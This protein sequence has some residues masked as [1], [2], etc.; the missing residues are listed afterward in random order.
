MKSLALKPGQ[1]VADIG[2]GTGFIAN[3][4]FKLSGRNNPIWRVDPSLEMQEVA[5]QKEGLYPVQKTAEE[6]CSDP[7]ISEIFD[8]VVCVTSAHHFVDPDAVYKGI[9][10]SLRPSGIFVQ[11]NTLKSGHPVFK[12]AEKLVSKS[13][14]RERETQFS[15]LNVIDLDAKISSDEFSFPLGVPKSKLYEMFRC[16]YMS[17]LDH[18]SDDQIEEGIRAGERGIKRCER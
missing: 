2:S 13:F 15:L 12:S 6:F 10:R 11:L 7:Q 14:E 17:I 3:E 18:F 4:L 5:Q 1:A 8:R 16:R 9:P